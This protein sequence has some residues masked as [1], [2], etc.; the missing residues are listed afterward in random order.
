MR[1]LGVGLLVGGAVSW[2]PT[3]PLVYVPSPSR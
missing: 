3:P 1:G 2:G